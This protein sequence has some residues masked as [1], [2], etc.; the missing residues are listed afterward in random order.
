MENSLTNIDYH[1]IYFYAYYIAIAVIFVVELLVPKRVLQ[2]SYAVRW[3]NNI[4]LSMV[5][6]YLLRFLLPIMGIDLALRLEAQG[7][8]LLNLFS[9]P[10]LL[11]L[12]CAVLILDFMEYGLHRLYHK[13]LILWRCHLVHHA[14]L[15][16]DFTTHVRHHP[17]EVLISLGVNLMVI[18]MLGIPAL[19]VFVY[20]IV[21]HAVSLFSHGN[22]ALPAGLDRLL[23]CFI[24]TPDMHHVHHSIDKPETNSNYGIVFP[25]W[26]HLFN[27]YVAQPKKGHLDMQLGLDR[28]RTRRDLFIDRLLILPFTKQA[29]Q[30]A[31]SVADVK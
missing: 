21:A 3:L 20:S 27:S 28:F 4:G 5:S 6:V 2:Y 25:W 22:I 8:G 11:K 13:Y 26:D 30:R 19:A 1:G 18:F 24:I 16:V 15:D 10:F 7:V 17:L 9:A 12:I 23:R 31:K 29:T 14:D